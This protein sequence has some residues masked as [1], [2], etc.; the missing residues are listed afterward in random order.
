M[1]KYLL[2]VA[3]LL[4]L[5]FDLLFWGKT[6]GISF[7]IFV[8]LCLVSGFFLIKADHLRPAKASWLLI[9]PILFLAVMSF[10]R[11]EPL[12]IFPEYVPALIPDGSAGD[13]VP[14]RAMDLIWDSRLCGKFISFDR[15]HALASL[16]RQSG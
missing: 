15:R 13:D 4:G 14:R 3:L 5:C 6:P 11:K 9:I 10:I 2:P 16:A 12:T 8:I 1:K 7:F